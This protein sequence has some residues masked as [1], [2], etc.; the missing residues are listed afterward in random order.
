[1][2]RSTVRGYTDRPSVAPGETVRF[3]LAGDSPGSFAAR[4]VRLV[5]GDVDPRGPGRRFEVV[6]AELS[7][8]PRVEPQ[9]VE[10]GG[11]V[12]VDAG[13]LDL[14]DGFTV[15]V[16]VYPT[17]PS[18]GRQGLLGQHDPDTRAGWL[19]E[20]D[21]HGHVAFGVGSGAR[22]SRVR[23][24]KPLLPEVWYSVVATYDAA[25][26][27][28]SLRQAPCVTRTNSRFGL[29]VPLDSTDEA[30][31]PC[32]VTPVAPDLPIVMAGI[33][34]SGARSAHAQSGFN[35][36][37][38]A[39]V[40]LRQPATPE[41][42]RRLERGERP[43]H[44]AYVA[45]WD[46]AANGGSDG[47]ASDQVVDVSGNGL[48]G[49]CWNT[50]DRGMTGWRW[51]GRREHYAYAPEEYGA[52]WFHDDSVDDCRWPEVLSW[53]IPA[54][55]RS[56][57]YALE[58]TKDG[59]RQEI[60][61]FVRPPR[62]R[63]GAKIAM[64][65]STFSYTVYGSVNSPA[66]GPAEVVW[67]QAT[68]L[69][70]ADVELLERGREWGPSGYEY[71]NDGAGCHYST[72]RRPNLNLQSGY[73]YAYGT[74]W[75][76]VSDLHILSWLEAKGF[77]YEVITDHDVHAEGAELLARYRLVISG[78]HPEYVSRQILDAWEDYLAGGGRGMYLGGNGWYWVTAQHPVKPFLL[79]VRRGETGDQTWKARP[80]EYHHSFTGERGGLWRN[81]GR[82]PQK[83]FGT[84][85]AAHGLSTSAP[86]HLLADA[87]D[88]RVEWIFA[89]TRDRERLGTSGL[90][91][92]GAV[93]QE[94][95]RYDLSLGSPPQAFLLGSSYGHT[96]Y[97][98]L[99]P[100]EQYSTAANI[101]GEE[102]PLVRG[103]LVFFTT[104]NGGAMFA[105]SSMTWATSLPV[106]GYDNDVSV[107]MANVVRRFAADEPIAFVLATDGSDAGSQAGVAPAGPWG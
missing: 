56:G 89:G 61:F 86:Y 33:L 39:P 107:V 7:G 99:V 34:A 37:L 28:L 10:I 80:G 32:D 42:A 71:H 3:H 75:N 64:L 27:T 96:K 23:S 78:S 38:E 58:A 46:F 72:W 101:N 104:P 100:E 19:L 1:M 49:V 91:G 16:F 95:D 57:V 48:H 84:G 13:A 4:I 73:R 35:G 8:T 92:G 2:I 22:E 50:P 53:K 47:F 74:S 30:L 102:H 24:G 52:I 82:A 26:R 83:I 40:L 25:A 17:L 70:P 55:C 45:R 41:L 103:D 18:K 12:R 67:A 106:D 9:R 14:S 6:E 98:G 36:K 90:V 31:A 59:V 29:V 105:A 66:E 65:M 97:D 79:E 63:C 54:E 93:G 88:A 94:F 43:A 44:A 20:I 62:G 81:R 51:S 5:N 60:V 15:Q 11:H 85:Y 21:A 87:R 76:L 68:E 77:P 69:D